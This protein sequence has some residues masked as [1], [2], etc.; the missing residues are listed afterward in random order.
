MHDSVSWRFLDYMFVK[1]GVNVKWRYWMH[2][3][4]FSGNLAV[5]V[6]GCPI[7]EINIQRGLK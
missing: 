7:H 3:N 5:L 1:F 4:A 2:V 6:N